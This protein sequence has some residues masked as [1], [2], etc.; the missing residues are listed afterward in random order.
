MTT[1]MQLITG[2]V[3]PLALGLSLRKFLGQWAR[4]NR[5]TL[6]LFDK[7]IILLIIYKSF[8]HAFEDKIF[9]HISFLS[10]IVMTILVIVL[11]YLVYYLTGWIG[12]V[13]KFKHADR[14]TK[15]Y[16][17]NKKSI[18]HDTVFSDALIG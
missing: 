4:N 12:K 14:I 7:F 10:M 17:I 5:R 8:V 18:V 16:C 11:F 2:I 13:L 6:D 9:I 15:H 1:Y 3:V